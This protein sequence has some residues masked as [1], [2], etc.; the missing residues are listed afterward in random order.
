LSQT[1]EFVGKSGARYRYMTI[2]ELRF[3]PPAGAN[4][5]IASRAGQ[6]WNVL[7]AGE[8]DNLAMRTWQDQLEE[9]KTRFGDV[10]ILTR[11]NVKSAVR[12]E[13]LNDMIEGNSPP[14]N[15]DGPAAADAPAHRG[16]QPAP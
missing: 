5:V 12:R 13:E 8:T 14:M 16:E 3:L 9:A 4:Y 15:V 10:E 6:V 1:I 2:E 7:M 11:L